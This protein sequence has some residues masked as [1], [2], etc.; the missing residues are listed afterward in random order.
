VSWK[1]TPFRKDPEKFSG[2]SPSGSTTR[3][4]LNEYIK[5][6]IPRAQKGDLPGFA[7]LFADI[8]RFRKI[9]SG[10]G[11]TRA[12]RLIDA[13]HQR[14]AELLR[15]DE[16]L[17]SPWMD[18]FVIVTGA[19]DS[20]RD[21][22]R[23]AERFKTAADTPFEIDGHEIYLTLSIGL[24]LWEPSCTKPEDLILN[25][26]ISALHAKKTGMDS[27]SVFDP[28]WRQHSIGELQL[29]NEL[30]R[31]LK[32]GEFRIYY[33]PIVERKSGRI[34]GLE[35]LARWQHPEY[36]LMPPAHFI[37]M[38]EETGLI[39]EMD[40]RLLEIACRQLHS[41]HVSI[42]AFSDLHLS[43]NISSLEFLHPDLISRID[44]TLRNT[45][46]YG[47]HIH[48]E[49]TESLLMDNTQYADQMLEQLR[50]LNIGIS[51]DDFGTG[52]SS[53]AYLRRFAIDTIKID[54]SFV[55]RMTRDEESA[56]IVRSIAALAENLG[57]TCVAE[58]VETRSQL[59]I[60]TRLGVD[61]LQGFY[62][63]PPLPPE[64]AEKLLEMV[65]GH[66]NHLDFILRD[67]MGPRDVGHPDELGDMLFED[68]DNLA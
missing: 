41:W 35:A 3:G 42:P 60:L 43:V 31:A 22:L 23:T 62:I 19:I 2:D 67:R 44:R 11:Y 45:G 26:D 56:E 55:R 57:K 49:L 32:K 29:Q 10:L 51:I 40:R 53:L 12:D 6:L 4:D 30:G 47:R 5:K 34:V 50:R 61:Y 7:V 28:A 18:Q 13:L 14:L 25:A 48:L 38:A 52:Y 64:S 17:S 16:Y 37:E 1:W 8:D 20:T 21:A 24:A 39:I 46:T 9:R 54:Y 59:D 58:G 63:S 66:E 65:Q 68:P 36:G 27:L 33:Q 15:P